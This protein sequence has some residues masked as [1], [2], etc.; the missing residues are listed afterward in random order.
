MP[1]ISF[2]S[3]EGMNYSLLGRWTLPG[4]ALGLM[5]LRVSD[6]VLLIFPMQGVVF[7]EDFTNHF[8]LYFFLLYRAVFWIFI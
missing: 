8:F 5:A 1:E 4:G 3:L 2:W 7:S 6:I